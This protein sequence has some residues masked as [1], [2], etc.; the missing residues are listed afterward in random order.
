VTGWSLAGY[1]VE[2][3]E[4]GGGYVAAHLSADVGVLTSRLAVVELATGKT[5]MLG[6]IGPLPNWGWTGFVIG[7]RTLL[8]G[9]GPGPGETV[10]TLYRFDLASLDALASQFPAP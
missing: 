3:V 7:G 8:A 1:Q 9:M 10:Q 6:P 2:H 4:V 5:W